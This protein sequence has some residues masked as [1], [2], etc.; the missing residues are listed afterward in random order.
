M[1][2]KQL[3]TLKRIEKN[4]ADIA[5]LKEKAENLYMSMEKI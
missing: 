3:E 5:I 2:E 4:I 1:N